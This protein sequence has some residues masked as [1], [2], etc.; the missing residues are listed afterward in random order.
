MRDERDLER[1]L[2]TVA[3]LPMRTPQE[4]MGQASIERVWLQ[5][6]LP[7]PIR[8]LVAK[9]H[10]RSR[11]AGGPGHL[12]S[13]RWFRIAPDA[14]GYVRAVPAGAWRGVARAVGA[15]ATLAAGLIN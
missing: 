5:L 11:G 1:A 14:A 4:W 3:G 6:R 10:A 2:E 15:A 9:P 7:E 12:S 8:Q 13:S